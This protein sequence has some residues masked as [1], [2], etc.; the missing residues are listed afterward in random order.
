MLMLSLVDDHEVSQ[1][2]ESARLSQHM[3][4]HLD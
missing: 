3:Q 1:F 4:P 2:I